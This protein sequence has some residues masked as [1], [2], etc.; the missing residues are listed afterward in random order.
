M[1][2]K[3]W[4]SLTIGI[5]D[6]CLGNGGSI[7]NGGKGG[8]VSIGGI[9]AISGIGGIGTAS[10]TTRA[11]AGSMVLRDLGLVTLKSIGT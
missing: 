2:S 4:I 8:K 11:G 6:E 9:G 5:Y 7:G 1:G 3:G 10:T